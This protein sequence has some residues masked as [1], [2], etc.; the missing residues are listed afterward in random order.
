MVPDRKMAVALRSYAVPYEAT[1]LRSIVAPTSLRTSF[2]GVTARF[3]QCH[4][5]FV[6]AVHAF[7]FCSAEMQ[8]CCRRLRHAGRTVADKLQPTATKRINLSIP[9]SSMVGLAFAHLSS[10]SHMHAAAIVKLLCRLALCAWLVSGKITFIVNRP[11]MKFVE[12]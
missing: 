6:L 9:P 3:L 7:R 2:T 8:Y 1:P 4:S 10:C 11:V 12:K 5:M